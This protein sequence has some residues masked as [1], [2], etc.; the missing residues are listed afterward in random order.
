MYSFRVSESEGTI[1]GVTYDD[2][3]SYSD[4]LVGDADMDGA[5]EIQSVTGYQNASA[6]YD[7]A[8]NMHKVDITVNNKYAPKGSANAKIKIQKTI[9]SLSGEEKSRAGFTFELYD[10]NGDLIKTSEQTSTAGET[11][12]DLTYEA[13]DAG[14]TFNYSLKETNSGQTVNGMTY[15]GTQ[16]NVSVTVKDN[17]DGTVSAYIYNTADYSTEIQTLRL[18]E[19]ESESK[20]AEGEESESAGES[21][22]STEST[23]TTESTAST[24]SESGST[25]ESTT[26][27]ESTAS[28]ESENESSAESKPESTADT[29]SI[30]EQTASKKLRA[31]VPALKTREVAVI[32]DGATNV[33]TAAFV[34]TY[35]PAD[36]ST[37]FDGKKELT[38]RSLKEGEFSFDLYDT[39]DGFTV[40]EGMSPIQS[41]KNNAD[42][43]FAFAE[44]PY[45]QVGTYRYVL[46]E[47][48]SAALGGISYDK[49][50]Y[51]ITVLVTDENGILK[52]SV[53]V[54]DE[55]GAAS[56]IV[57]HNR[58][59]AA[60]A[61]VTLT[62]TKR[63]NGAQLKANMFKFLLYQANENFA[64]QGAAMEGAYNTA[65][66]SFAFDKIDYTSAG[67]HYY[68]VKEDVSAKEKDIEY[69]TTSYGITVDVRDD[70]KGQLTADT[71]IR[72]IGGSEVDAIFFEN[73]YTGGEEPK[74]PVKPDKPADPGK[75]SVPPDTPV[76]EE[77]KV[78][79]GMKS[80]KSGET[81]APAAVL[82]T[83][84]ASAMIM[85][86][87]KKN[88]D[89]DE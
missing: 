3:V 4:V 44:I 12:I 5:L 61:S 82:L 57:F 67:K 69:D 58:Y 52:T 28:A 24:G 15:D 59:T 37:G 11:F 49:A 2:V 72:K 48:A 60:A 64:I 85:F 88:E 43:S 63:L 80:P 74:D 38:G 86:R 36:T 10:E 51:R 7:T 23:T 6:S 8:S 70:G 55:L 29:D 54:T 62:G 30:A 32:P 87:R 68:V 47:D 65:S 39:G 26:T 9:N 56:D 46:K 16:Y 25:A 76:R 66:G 83:T 41:V 79:E 21:T 81:S 40:T 22:A 77:H 84:L 17:L 53:S 35:D 20:E 78:P 27:T 89:T 71:T 34:N 14:T 42:G 75:P 73:S 45:S 13:K 31:S 50:A 33:Y 1:G 19:T 18:E